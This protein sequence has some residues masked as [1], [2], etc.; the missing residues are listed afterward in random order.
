MADK[1]KSAITEAL[2]ELPLL[3]GVDLEDEAEQL[4][5]RF[6]FALLADRPRVRQSRK[7]N[8][9]RREIEGLIEQIADL[10]CTVRGLHRRACEAVDAEALR[11]GPQK[12]GRRT[13]PTLGLMEINL[14]ALARAALRALEALPE[15]E[16]LVIGPTAPGALNVT[17]V[18]L[19]AF[20]NLTGRA[21]TVVVD[22]RNNEAKG[23]FV[24]FVRAIFNAYGLKSSPVSMARKAIAEAR[25]GRG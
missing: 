21:A 20:E 18:C 14:E 22:T 2:Q 15:N 19:G 16:P 12:N 25:E 5:L 10:H 1:L 23:P 17:K 7:P 13:T 9:A 4:G 3:D 6:F 24:L 8:E 11:D